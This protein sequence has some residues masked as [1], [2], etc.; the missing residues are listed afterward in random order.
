MQKLFRLRNNF[1]EQL[2]DEKRHL[3]IKYLLGENKLYSWDCGDQF[4]RAAAQKG[5]L[6]FGKDPIDSFEQFKYYIPV[7][8]KQDIMLWLMNE[9]GVHY[10]TIY[11]DMN[12]PYLTSARKIIYKAGIENTPQKKETKIVG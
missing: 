11:P 12:L 5:F 4:H 6:L 1:Y 10:I 8:M 3:S 7:T 2:P 9:I